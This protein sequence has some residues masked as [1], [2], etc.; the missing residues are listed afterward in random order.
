MRVQH[1]ASVMVCLTAAS[2]CRADDWVMHLT[3]DNQFDLYFGTPAATTSFEGGGTSWPTTF[4]F[5]ATGRATSDYIYVATASDQTQ[6]QGFIGDFTNTTVGRTSI[7]GDAVWQVF[8]AGAFLSQMG[9]GPG[10]WP[11]SLQP[12]RAQV[13]IA[14]AYA[15]Q[16]NLWVAPTSGG[17]NGVGPWGLRPSIDANARWIWYNA[18]GSPDPTQGSFNHDEFLVFRLAGIVPAPG[19]LAFLVLGATAVSRRR[20]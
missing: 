12:T 13:D 3:C 15:T 6:A 11:A 2:A 1:L 20:R 10:P 4:T 7:T 19:S 9:L 14:I 5:S 8:N 16:Q 18:N 17:Q